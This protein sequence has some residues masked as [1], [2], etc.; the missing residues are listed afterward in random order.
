MMIRKIINFIDEKF[1]SPNMTENQEN[2][3]EEYDY[4]EEIEDRHY[5][6]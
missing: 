4:E 2:E 1:T 5:F 3:Y 6:Y